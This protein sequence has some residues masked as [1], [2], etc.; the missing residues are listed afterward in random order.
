MLFCEKR[1]IHVFLFGKMITHYLG[2]NNTIRKKISHFRKVNH[3]MSCFLVFSM[4]IVSRNAVISAQVTG[5]VKHTPMK[6]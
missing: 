4:Y 6:P 1:T 2:K 3:S 5:S